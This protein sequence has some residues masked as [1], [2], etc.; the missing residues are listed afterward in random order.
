MLY[1]KVRKFDVC[2]DNS[3]KVKTMKRVEYDE[4]KIQKYCV[5]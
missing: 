2:V 5:K 3:L 1:R 4:E